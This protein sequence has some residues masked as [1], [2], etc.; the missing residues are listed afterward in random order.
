MDSSGLALNVLLSNE[1]VVSKCPCVVGLVACLSRDTRSM[2][3]SN[4]AKKKYNCRLALAVLKGRISMNRQQTNRKSIA[5]DVMYLSRTMGSFL[6]CAKLLA[7]VPGPFTVEDMQ[8]IERRCSERNTDHPIAVA[9]QA[10][11]LRR[12]VDPA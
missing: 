10:E 4:Q 7:A 2:A 1:N 8:I 6:K 5:Y 11:E 9:A 12:C 3:E